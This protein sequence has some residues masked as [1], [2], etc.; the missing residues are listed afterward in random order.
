MADHMCI[1]ISVSVSATVSPLGRPQFCPI[2]YKLFRCYSGRYVPVFVKASVRRL[3]LVS[4]LSMILLSNS[5]QKI[6]R[7]DGRISVSTP[8][9]CVA[10]ISGNFLRFCQFSLFHPF[11]VGAFCLP[12]WLSLQVCVRLF[13]A[14]LTCFEVPD[15]EEVFV[16][17]FILVI[18]IHFSLSTFFNILNLSKKVIV[19]FSLLKILL[20]C[21]LTM[22]KR[23]L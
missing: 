15:G 21:S 16:E 7:K 18:P 13:Y 5:L 12:C 23:F 1:F 20:C 17:A 2:P 10:S 11:C 19:S 3:L 14:N 8:Q 4:T 22:R 6:P 9:S